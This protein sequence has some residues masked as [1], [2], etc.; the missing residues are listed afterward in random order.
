MARASIVAECGRFFRNGLGL[1]LVAISFTLTASPALAGY[2]FE[3]AQMGTGG[4]SSGNS[5]ISVQYL[6][7]RFHLPQAA[8]VSAVGGHIFSDTEGT[9]FVAIA[10]LV[11]L[12]GFPLGEPSN[13]TPLAVTTFVAPPV[14][15][16]ADVSIPLSVELPAGDY[17]IIFGSGRFGATASGAMPTNN[18]PLDLT[19]L[20]FTDALDSWR[21]P[22]NQAMRFTVSG[23]LVPEPSGMALATIGLAGV[24]GLVR[25]KW[26]GMQA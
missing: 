1:T 13:F 11:S 4:Q 2:L 18:S 5:V 10:P 24:L 12:A 26:R 3:T 16:S 19:G 9:L 25:R 23:V 15:A 6:G 14:F 17:A 21:V 20:F 22:L 8:E 7:A